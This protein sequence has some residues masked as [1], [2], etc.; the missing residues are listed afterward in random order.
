MND[1][2]VLKGGEFLIRETEAKDI[3]IPEEFDE[4]QRMMAQTCREF[5]ETQVNPNMDQL[6]KL[7]E[8]VLQNNTY[9]GVESYGN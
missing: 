9:V 8:Q 3:F 1:K 2:K 7:I 6:E 5:T 4:E